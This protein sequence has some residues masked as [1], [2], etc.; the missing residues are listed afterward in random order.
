ME[1]ESLS[2]E[3]TIDGHVSYDL[4]PRSQVDFFRIIVWEGG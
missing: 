1:R 4:F 2:E 3:K